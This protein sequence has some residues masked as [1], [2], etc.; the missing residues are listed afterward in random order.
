MTSLP[1]IPL[2]ILAGLNILPFLYPQVHARREKVWKPWQ[3]WTWGQDKKCD[4]ILCW[5][6]QPPV[7]GIQTRN[8]NM[9]E[10]KKKEIKHKTKEA[11]GVGV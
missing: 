4:D 1:F 5:Q 10:N 8:S 11:V 2:D 9:E 7:V 6:A 3:R